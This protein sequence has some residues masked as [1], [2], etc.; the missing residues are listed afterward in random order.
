MAELYGNL[1]SPDFPPCG[2]IAGLR[3]QLYEYQRRSV[4]ALQ[5]KESS[6]APIPDP[7]YIPVVGMNGTT[8]YLQPNQMEFLRSR[9]HVSTNCGGI[10]CEELGQFAT[11]SCAFLVD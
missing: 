7:L 8:F 9:P 6:T 5:H 2:P 3:S 4:S 11:L 10:L 1:P